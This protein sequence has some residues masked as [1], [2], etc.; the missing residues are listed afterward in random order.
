[1]PGQQEDLQREAVICDGC[2][3]THA[4]V[5]HLGVDLAFERPARIREPA[6][7]IWIAADH[8]PQ[9]EQPQDIREVV[10]ARR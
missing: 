9:D 3:E 5:E 4:V 10:I 1:M 6:V 2:L 7:G 8:G